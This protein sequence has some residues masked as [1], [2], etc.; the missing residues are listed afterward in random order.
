MF[1]KEDLEKVIKKLKTKST[2]GKDKINN[3]MLFN[4]S[5]EFRDIILHLI[6]ITV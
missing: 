3:M 2:P 6:N 1:V 4:T 5:S